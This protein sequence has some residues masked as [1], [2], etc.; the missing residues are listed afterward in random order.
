MEKKD[1]K[2]VC[3]VFNT[4]CLSSKNNHEGIGLRNVKRRLE[5]LYPG[6]HELIIEEGPASYKITLTLKLQ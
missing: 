5:L 2:L 6:R 3:T 4:S 1:G